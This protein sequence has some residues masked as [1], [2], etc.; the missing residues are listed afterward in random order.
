MTIQ[1]C[2]LQC[3]GDF[4]ETLMRLP[5]ER[6]I[7]RFLLRFLEDPSYGELADGIAAANGDTAY[8]AAY[9]L[10]GV[11]MDLGLRALYESTGELTK[12]LHCG[13]HDRA[14]ELFPKVT[15]AYERTVGAIRVYRESMER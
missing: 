14:C 1:E 7:Q 2:Y 13:W 5:S 11:A 10:N 9:K 12:L 6:M 15:A 3:G 4:I 8:R